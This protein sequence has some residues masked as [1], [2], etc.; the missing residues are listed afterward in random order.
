MD[1]S[2]LTVAELKK[3]IREY[4]HIHCKPY[5]KLNRDG[6]LSLAREFEGHLKTESK[7]AVRKEAHKVILSRS[8]HIGGEVKE[9]KDA[10]TKAMHEVYKTYKSN[11]GDLSFVEFRLQNKKAMKEA[12]AKK[13]KAAGAKKAPS[14]KQLEA[15]RKFVEMVRAKSAAKKGEAKPVK[16]PKAPRVAKPK[17]EK[18]SKAVARLEPESD[19]NKAIKKQEKATKLLVSAMTGSKN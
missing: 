10:G 19:A 17:G 8:K 3:H 14:E 11:G 2:K 18:V 1:Y 16:E 9:P 7:M 4:K 13:P 12:A 15:R 6:L 5:S